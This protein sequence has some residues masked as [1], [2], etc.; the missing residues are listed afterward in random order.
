M[1]EPRMIFGFCLLG[2]IAILAVILALGKVEEHTSFGLGIVLGTLGPLAGGF[3]Q[4][5]FS[6][7]DDK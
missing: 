6:K 1:W 3:S 2:T 7:K 4:W 5:A